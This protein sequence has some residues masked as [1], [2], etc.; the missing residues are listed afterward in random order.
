MRFRAGRRRRRPRNFVQ[1]LLTTDERSGIV[2][3]AV[4]ERMPFDRMRRRDFISLI[5]ATAA[6]PLAAGAQQT[7][8]PVIGFLAGA[9]AVASKATLGGFRQ[10]LRQTGYIEGQNA[11]IAF[12]WSDG[13]NNLLPELAAELVS[14]QVAVIAAFGAPAVMAA[15]SA[16]KTIPIAFT[17]GTDPVKLGLVASLNRPGGNA[18][19][20]VFLST[21]LLGKHFELLREMLPKATTMGLLINS[22]SA[23]AE[24]QLASVPDV[25]KALGLKIVVQ[26]ASQDRDLEP[27]FEKLMQQRIQG[28]VIGSDAFFYYQRAQLIALASR[29]ALPV[30][31]YDRE[32][33][34]DGGLISYGTSVTDAYRQA[35]VFTGRMLKGDKPGDLPV[36]QAIKTDL[37]I[38]LQTAKALGI[39]MPLSLLMR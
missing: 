5:G 30:M 27:A 7:P 11:H 16:T 39:E 17:S 3:P 2:G 15:L 8:I 4:S 13:R 10:G 25:S 6:W 35:G 18:T 38:N 23:N 31:Y 21:D 36:Q 20:V 12:R 22:S 37:V 29:H 1:Y 14:L 9:S 28:L 33:V 26:S 24:V 19:G 34:A 32:Y